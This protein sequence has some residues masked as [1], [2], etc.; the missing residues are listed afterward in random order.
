MA[1]NVLSNEEDV[2]AIQLIGGKINTEMEIHLPAGRW[3]VTWINPGT[4]LV[5]NEYNM[6]HSKNI[7]SINI[8][9]DSSH[10][11]TLLE[12]DQ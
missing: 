10:L 12:K 3:K 1:A 6:A 8:P 11:I 9:T 2:M 5:L 4:G 7:L